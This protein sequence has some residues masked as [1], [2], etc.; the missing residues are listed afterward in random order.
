MK[1]YNKAIPILITILVTGVFF[2]VLSPVFRSQAGSLAESYLYLSR[3]QTSL[4]GTGS[5]DVEMVLAFQA[6]QS[7]ANLDNARVDIFFPM[8]D[9]AEWCRT[10]GALTVTGVA[11]AAPDTSGAIEITASL[12]GTLV[13]ACTQGNGTTTVDTISITGV[14]DIG[15]VETYGVK[16]TSNTGVLGTSTTAGS[17]TTT[18]QVSDD[19]NL[20]SSA[21]GVYLLTDDTVEVT[22]TVAAAP[23]VTCTLSPVTVALGTLYPGGGLVEVSSTN[24]LSTSSTNSGYY[25]AAYG[26]GNGTNAGL[27]YAGGPYLIQSGTGTGTVDISTGGTEGFGINLTQPS[28][29][30]VTTDFSYTANGPGVYGS[31]GATE[32]GARLILYKATETSPAHSSTIY[33]G[34]RAGSSA[35]SGS[36]TE[37]VTY[38]CGGYY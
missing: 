27:Y 36:Y 18:V 20:D 33:Y 19:N 26:Q 6:S 37:Y 15:N 10:A 31:L 4:D 23:T 24:Q 38:V 22:A 13:A 35:L 5:N 12:P 3:I 11:S 8:D 25:W 21:F 9:N 34:A 16:L 7:F 29:A 14:G 2:F 1:K 17:R 32:A 30:T 28:G